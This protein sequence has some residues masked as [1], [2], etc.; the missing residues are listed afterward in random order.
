MALYELETVARRFGGRYVRREMI[1]GQHM[2]EGYEARAEEM[3]IQVI[4]I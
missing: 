3:G 2:T 4:Y 1:A